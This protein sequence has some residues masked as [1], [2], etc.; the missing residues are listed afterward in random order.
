MDAV[1]GPRAQSQRSR[2]H[3]NPALPDSLKL[4]VCPTITVHK[5]TLL[6]CFSDL[7]QMFVFES[8]PEKRGF[9]GETGHQLRWPRWVPGEW[10]WTLGSG[11]RMRGLGV[12]PHGGAPW[13]PAVRGVGLEQWSLPM[14][15]VSEAPRLWAS[16]W[17]QGGVSWADPPKGVWRLDLG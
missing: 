7:V 15:L 17:E 16:A 14:S 1:G 2:L 8:I 13:S 6:Y 11:H 12:R 10:S 9:E 3:A 4:V 5:N